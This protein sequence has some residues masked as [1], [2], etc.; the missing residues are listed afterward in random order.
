MTTQHDER[1]ELI[2]KFEAAVHH[3]GELWER[4][5]GKGWPEAESKTFHKLRDERIPELRAALLAADSRAGGEVVSKRQY[6]TAMRQWD[7]WKSYALELQ[8]KLVKY[9]GGSPMILNTRPAPAEPQAVAQGWKLV[10]VEPNKAA[11]IGE[12]RFEIE[13]TCHAC[14]FHGEQE[15]CEVCGGNVQYMQPVTVPW[16]TIKEIYRAML[17]ASPAEP[18]A[19]IVRHGKPSRIAFEHHWQKT[20]GG[21][22]SRNELQRHP[23]QPQTYVNDSANRHWVT[24]QAAQAAM[25]SA[26]HAAPA[27]TQTRKDQP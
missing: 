26:P 13:L 27:E 21:K 14:S 4:C 5:Q 9:E 3:M 7:S 8:A 15:H 2:R 18:Q 11:L 19:V 22:K 12:F 10:P 16:T 1:V 24:W 17:S 6:E 20:R 23:L 25:L